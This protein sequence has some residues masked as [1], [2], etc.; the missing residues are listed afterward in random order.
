MILLV[1]NMEIVDETNGTFT[2]I[3]SSEGMSATVYFSPV[4]KTLVITGNNKLTGVLKKNEYQFRK[5][6]H[7]KRRKSWHTG[8]K[9]KFVLR[10]EKDIAAFNDFSKTIIVDKRD[11]K[12]E[13]Y[14][15]DTGKKEITELFIDGSYMKETGK[16]G[17]AVII[18]SDNGK[19]DLKTFKTDA[20]SSS[21]IELLAAIKGLE[22]LPDEKEVRIITDSQYV[23]KGLTEWIINWKLNNW[24]TAN[25]EKVKNIEYW[26]RFDRLTDDRYI[27]F[28]YVKA[29]SDHFENTMADLYAKDMAKQ[30]SNSQQGF[31]YAQ[32]G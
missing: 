20:Q 10:D 6:L 18:K 30:S 8:F 12:Y 24:T 29:H 16:G 7:M 13:N 23:R 4:S 14:V 25:G 17:Y 22:L 28:K 9:L 11:G 21:L 32:P 3:V 31:D 5:V 2:I 19:Y 1:L 27:E 15:A 26:K